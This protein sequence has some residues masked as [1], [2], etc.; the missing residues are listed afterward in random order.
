LFDIFDLNESY[1]LT[2]MDLEFAIQCVVMSTSKIF[3]IG[4]DFNEAEIT[5]IVR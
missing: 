5:L 1:H 4:A 2:N 3:N